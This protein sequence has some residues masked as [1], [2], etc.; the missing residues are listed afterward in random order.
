MLEVRNKMRNFFIGFSM[1]MTTM[2][3]MNFAFAGGYVGVGF[4]GHYL[5]FYPYLGIDVYKGK[6]STGSV[7]LSYIDSQTNLLIAVYNT[8]STRLMYLQNI[9]MTEET[10]LLL[11]GGLSHLTGHNTVSFSDKISSYNY[12]KPILS[13]GIKTKLTANTD[14]RLTWEASIGDK[15]YSS[16]HKTLSIGVSYIF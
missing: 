10:Y 11:G 7:E 2:L 4:N 15:E 16:A 13:A 5:E 9:P 3:G 8:K 12:Y 1:L 6:K 14:W